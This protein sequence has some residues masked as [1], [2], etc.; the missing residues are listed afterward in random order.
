MK[1]KK[2]NIL[3]REKLQSGQLTK[4]RSKKKK[5]GPESQEAPNEGSHPLHIEDRAASNMDEL[6]ARPAKR[7]KTEIGPSL[8]GKPAGESP[9]AIIQDI[10][11]DHDLCL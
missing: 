8:G 10:R 2:L 7:L 11:G 6:P 5:S 1:K 3:S 4:A 9:L